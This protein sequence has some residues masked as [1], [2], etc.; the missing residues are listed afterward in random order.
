[1]VKVCRLI[2]WVD[3]WLILARY[4]FNGNN[5]RNNNRWRDNDEAAASIIKEV[6]GVAN[7]K[8]AFRADNRTSILDV[9]LFLRFTR[10]SVVE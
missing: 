9:V 4:G 5:N 8:C 3:R 10:F 7:T 6:Y 2:E 1:M